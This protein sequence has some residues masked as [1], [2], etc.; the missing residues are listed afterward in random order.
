MVEEYKKRISH[1]LEMY[2]IMEPHEIL[3][4]AEI[5][6]CI[7]TLLLEEIFPST[8]AIQSAALQY[9]DI[10]IPINMIEES[11]NNY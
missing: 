3:E 11:I 7:S 5:M 9:A 8:K 10:L 6:S 1:F 4:D 2:F